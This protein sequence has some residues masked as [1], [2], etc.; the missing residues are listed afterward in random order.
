MK[1]KKENYRVWLFFTFLFMTVIYFISN[2]PYEAQDIKPFENNIQMNS[3]SVPNVQIKYDHQVVSSS[4]PYEFVEFLFRKTGHII[5]YCA[6]TLLWI[7]TLNYTKL[8]LG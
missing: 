3:T 6:L 4:S 7:K 2:M 1:R 5:G 8:T